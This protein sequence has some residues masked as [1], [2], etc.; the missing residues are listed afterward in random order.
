MEK[1]IVTIELEVLT[2]RMTDREITRDVER[3]AMNL[4]GIESGQTTIEEIDVKEIR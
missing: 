4:K 3:L 2:S 1:R